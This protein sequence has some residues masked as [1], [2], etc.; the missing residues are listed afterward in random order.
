MR[1]HQPQIPPSDVDRL[2][3]APGTGAIQMV[4]NVGPG[5]DRIRFKRNCSLKG[6]LLRETGD[7]V[8]K[9]MVIRLF[10]KGPHWCSRPMKLSTQENRWRG[11][12][13][14]NNWSFYWIWGTQKYHSW[15]GNVISKPKNEIKRHQIRTK[16]EPAKLN[17]TYFRMWNHDLNLVLMR[18][19]RISCLDSGGDVVFQS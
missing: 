6:W 4:L 5:F 2:G 17:N 7:F 14:L 19:P 3:A 9:R 10:G 18:L 1:L 15:T 8:I 16:T 12:V 13:C 11:S